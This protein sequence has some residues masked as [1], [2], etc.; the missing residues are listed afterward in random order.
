MINSMSAKELKQLIDSGED[1]VLIDCREQE[2]WNDAHIEK[3]I[4]MPLS[5]FR[6]QMSKLDNPNAKIVI[7]CR[8][9]VRSLKACEML[10]E[11]GFSN[12][13]NLEGG[14]LDWMDEGYEI[15]EGE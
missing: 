14:I 3:A 11:D 10:E 13:T 4:F 9:G 7:Q 1:F 12:L 15:V 6:S 2:E 8:S 5:D